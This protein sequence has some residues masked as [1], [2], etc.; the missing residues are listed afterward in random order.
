MI[1]FINYLLA[2][3][4]LS[5]SFFQS[6]IDLVAH[7]HWVDSPEEKCRELFQLKSQLLNAGI[8]EPDIP[9]FAYAHTSWMQL[10]TI[11]KLGSYKVDLSMN[12]NDG[13]QLTSVIK[14]YVESM[15]ALRPL[16]MVLK[17]LLSQ[18]ELNSP[19]TSGLASYSLT[20]M[21]ISFLQV[22][23]SNRLFSLSQFIIFSVEPGQI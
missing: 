15:P 7:T 12:N 2:T 3:K 9:V 21:V 18:K 16:V 10:H 8:V 6:D 5:S 14:Q 22:C 11:P 13:I 23:I 4:N 20:C 1:I 17:A 19:A